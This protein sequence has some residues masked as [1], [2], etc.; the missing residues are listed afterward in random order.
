M[1]IAGDEDNSSA[2]FVCVINE[3]MEKNIRRLLEYADDCEEDE[4]RSCFLNVKDLYNNA[5][6]ETIGGFTQK[7]TTM[8]VHELDKIF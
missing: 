1:N 5:E 2:V 6:I 4:L 8:C 7:S 3:T